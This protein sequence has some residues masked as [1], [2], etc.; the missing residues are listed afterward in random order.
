M[1]SKIGFKNLKI[2]CVIG[3]LPEER[4]IKQEIFVDLSVT[5]DFTESV[6]TDDIRFGVDYVQLSDLC[7]K[8]AVEGK[9][10][11]LETYSEAVLNAVL[12]QFS[13]DEV[14]ICV[15]KP[16]GIAGADHAFVENTR[17]RVCVGRS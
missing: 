11:L 4:E 5:S 9:Y 16:M 12:N 15:R 14:T 2:L 10:H 6:K 3:D 17:S 8:I 1:M 7:R 13:V